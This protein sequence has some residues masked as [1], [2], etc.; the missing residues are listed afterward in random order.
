VEYDNH[1]SNFND[2]DKAI[3]GIYGKLMGLVEPVVVLGELRADLMEGAENATF[4]QV[5]ISNHTVTAAN[6]YCNVAPFY[7]V[8]LNCND[9]LA[10]FDK[11][12]AESKLSNDEYGYRY[13]DVMTVRCWVYL[14]LAIHFGNIPYVTDPLL[15]VDELSDPAKFAVKTF[16]EVLAELALCMEN[17]PVKGLSIASPLYNSSNVDGNDMRLV[18]LN[19]NFVRGDIHLWNGSY[20]RAAE[21]YYDVISDAEINLGLGENVLYKVDGYVWDG[22]NEPRF[23]VTYRRYKDTDASSYRN[24]WKE[25][26]A[27]PQSSAELRRE[28]INVLNYD[29]RFVPQY[30]LI[31]LFANT[32]VGKYQLK[33]TNRIINELWEAQMQREGIR[34][35]GRGRQAS[36]DYPTNDN[37]KPVALKY[38][39]EYYKGGTDY[40]RD[41]NNTIELQYDNPEFTLQGR[42]FIYR[43]GLLH[44]RYAEAVNR[45]GYPD[46]AYAIINGGISGAYDWPRSNGSRRVDKAGVQYSSYPPAND[47]EKAE[48]YP[49][50]FFLDARFNSA[51]YEYY[52]SPWRENNGVRGRAFL[53]S[54]P[55]DTL[56][57]GV[58]ITDPRA[59]IPTDENHP[60]VR[61]FEEHILTEAAMECAF[62]G[63][64]WGDMLRIALRKKKY[65]E[66]G[67]EFLNQT[68]RKA[69]PQVTVSEADLFLPIGKKEKQ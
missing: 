4:D 6:K 54:I 66:N 8:I 57:P 24:K 45:A 17:L 13:A 69:K 34:F 51:P 61:W 10:N 49:Y 32:G 15:T 29:A 33:P 42:W 38:L 36:F 9:A 22:S 25:I 62:E 65:G 19:K 2:A 63:H 67:I 21:C 40:K 35:D 41:L 14:Q 43:A 1:Y 52:R 31:E 28:G 50:P 20:R 30:P 26:F 5:D 59:Q 55:T 44:L 68:L 56:P 64:R 39:Y 58:W 12:K 60:A 23:Q 27:L 16:D 18:L 7:E 53:R 37:T 46:L 3:L 48:Q 11:M 47:V